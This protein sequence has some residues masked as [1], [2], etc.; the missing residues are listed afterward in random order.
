[1]STFITTKEAARFLNCTPQ[2][3]YNIRSRRK[4]AIEQGDSE[5]AKKVAPEAIKIGGKLLFE[6]STLEAWLRKY[7]EVA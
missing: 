4:V 2:H 6:E 5:L 7:G 3:L 1:M